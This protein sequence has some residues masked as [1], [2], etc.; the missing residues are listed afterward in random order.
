MKKVW[1][2]L[3]V[4]FV[5]IHFTGCVFIAEEEVGKQ[6]DIL[7]EQE[8]VEENKDTENEVEAA[9]DG[10]L[11]DT[12][13]YTLEIPKSWDGKYG[14]HVVDREDHTYTFWISEQM[15]Y[16]DIGGGDLFSILLLPG[17]E[18]YTY[19]P[20]YDVLGSFTSEEIG[21]FNIVVL[22][23]TDVQFSDRGQQT[24]QEMT[25]GIESVLDSISFKEGYAYSETPIP[26][27][28]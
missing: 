14:Y 1:M 20:S 16:E 25:A 15:S 22:Y 26:I 5:S 27:Q 12:E 6:E 4:L 24:Y 11:I 18:D 17:G 7:Y 9:P 10:T 3:V 13:Y 23:P 2:S 19:Y 8:N 28:N 21:S